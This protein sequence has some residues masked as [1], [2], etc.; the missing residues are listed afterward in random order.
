[1]HGI[2]IAGD[3]ISTARKQGKVRKAFIELG[4][5]ANIT[6]VDLS[7]QMKNLADFDFEI[8]EKK[9]VVKCKCGY[10]GKPNVIER[11]HEAVVIEC[12]KCKETPEILVGDKII[13]KSVDVE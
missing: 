12:P 3:L 2:H 10:K 4:E 11:L 1:M 13:L 8:N 7:N 6:E 5:I 9:A